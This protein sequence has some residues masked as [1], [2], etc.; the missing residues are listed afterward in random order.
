M[1]KSKED[2]AD[3]STW[4]TDRWVRLKLA[5]VAKARGKAIIEV[6]NVSDAE[7]S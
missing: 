6:A 3:V 5:E 2:L 7:S 4:R 1:D